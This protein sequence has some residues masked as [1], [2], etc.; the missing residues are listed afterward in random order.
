MNKYSLLFPILL[1][2]G[3]VIAQPTANGN[4]LQAAKQRIAILADQ[5]RYHD[6]AQAEAYRSTRDDNTQRVQ[7]EL[8]G[9]LGTGFA[10]ETARSEDIQAALTEL[11]SNQPGDPEHSGKIV[12]AYCQSSFWKVAG[13]RVYACPR[14]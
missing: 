12:C 4:A 11:L 14:W 9:Y 13:N 8:D 6:A 5:L 7:Q 1:M 3:S 2:G 10:L